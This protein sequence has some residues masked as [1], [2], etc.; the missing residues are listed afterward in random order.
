M[1]PYEPPVR[2]ST[3]EAMGRRFEQIELKRQIDNELLT[4]IDE[5]TRRM[6]SD[7]ESFR[8]ELLR[9]DDFEARFGPVRNYV[10]GIISLLSFSVGGAILAYFLRKT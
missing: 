7:I 10:Y 4:R 2:L 1:A 3:I 5:R 6:A 9:K 8:S